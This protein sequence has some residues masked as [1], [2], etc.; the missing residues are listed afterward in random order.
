MDRSLI[1]LLFFTWSCQGTVSERS[2]PNVIIF[3][4]DDLGWMDVGYNG[5]EYY[6]TP[7]IDRLATEGIIFNQA[8]ANA[9]FCSPSR[10]SLLTGLYTP[11]HEVYIPG[12]SERGPKEA[13]RLTPPENKHALDTSFFT[14]AEYFQIKGYKT[15]IIGK[16]HLG[17]KNHLPLYQGFD[18]NIG[19]TSSG[20]PKSYFS[21]YQDKTI[22][23]GPPGEYLTDRLTEEAIG[24]IDSHREKPFFLYLSHY[25]PHTPLEAKKELVDTYQGKLT[26][27]S[28]FNPVYAAMVESLDQSL[29]RLQD[30]LNE[31]GLAKNTI[32]IFYSDNG[33]Y[34]LATS[35]EPPRGS[36]G[37]LY[38]GGIRVPMIVKWPQVITGGRET[39]VV[40]S[41]VDLFPTF[42]ELLEGATPVEALDGESLVSLWKSEPHDLHERPIFWYEPVYLD[43]YDSARY[44]RDKITHLIELTSYGRIKQKR[45]VEALPGD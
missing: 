45:S 36:K 31:T 4:A 29:G 18:V 3:Y 25:A 5:N 21:P 38:E 35:N 27:S 33:G 40:V 9:P 20:K 17:G 1:I 10:A 13:Q 7:N 32:L 22:K 12:K 44:E 30:F 28:F 14:M 41:G 15:G 2:T 11:K 34:A 16:W 37:N 19:G 24:F 23:D 26:H 42:K 8:Y 43:S 6:E 39:D